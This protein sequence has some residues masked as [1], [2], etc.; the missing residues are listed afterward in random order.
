MLQ[1]VREKA[2]ELNGEFTSSRRSRVQF[3]P[4]TPKQF[5]GLQMC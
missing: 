5:P 2:A 3:T 4:P 1:K